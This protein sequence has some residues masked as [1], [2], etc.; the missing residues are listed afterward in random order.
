MHSLLRTAFCVLLAVSTASGVEDA[1]LTLRGEVTAQTHIPLPA[2]WRR[3]ARYRF[4]VDVDGCRWFIRAERTDGSLLTATETGWEGGH[5]YSVAYTRQVD[6]PEWTVQLGTVMPGPFPCRTEE[7]LVTVLWLGLASVCYFQTNTLAGQ[8]PP[9]FPGYHP[10]LCLARYT[11]PAHFERNALPP[12]FLGRMAGVT[13]GV[14]R[15]WPQEGDRWLAPPLEKRL[16]PPYDQGN[17]NFVYA[18]GG[19]RQVGSLTVPESF[20]FCSYLSKRSG[21]NRHDLARDY[22]CTAQVT[23]AAVGPPRSSYLP[24]LPAQTRI[25]D[26]RFVHDARPVGDFIYTAPAAQWLT[27]AEVRTL[28]E[29]KRQVGREHEMQALRQRSGPVGTARKATLWLLGL[30]AVSLGFLPV[31]RHLARR[32]QQRSTPMADQP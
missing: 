5:I 2:G 15:Y 24:R 19:F 29:Y 10:D 26:Y 23:H 8:F 32:E 31:W 4:E 3:E 11:L 6:N 25:K 14:V 21:T 9:L 16:S 22:E 30:C 20:T 27:E 1:A 13:D 18:V 7:T 12:F 17:T 28:P